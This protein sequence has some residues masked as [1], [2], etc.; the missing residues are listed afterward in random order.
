MRW[1]INPKNPPWRNVA[2]G[3]ILVGIDWNV[4]ITRLGAGQSGHRSADATHPSAFP[5]L[6]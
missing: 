3:D 5:F 1:T 4:H 6:R 2:N